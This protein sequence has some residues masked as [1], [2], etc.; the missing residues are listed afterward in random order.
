[1]PVAQ[2]DWLPGGSVDQQMIGE[3]VAK[4]KGCWMRVGAV[5]FCEYWQVGC[6]TSVHC[7]VN[8]FVGNASLDVVSHQLVCRRGLL[9]VLLAARICRDI[10]V[11]QYC[12]SRGLPVWYIFCT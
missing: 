1:M 3:N 2:G 4:M 8:D 11:I 10:V 6:S 7:F 12:R 5:I 9:V